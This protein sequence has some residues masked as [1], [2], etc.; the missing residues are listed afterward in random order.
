MAKLRSSPIVATD[1]AEYLG[2]QDDFSLELFVYS[3]SRSFGFTSTHGGTYEDPVTKKPRQY[4]VRA[5]FV[6]EQQR[7]DL[8]IECK[9]LRT[10]F[11]LLVS[12]IPRV[13][14]ESFHHVI[15]SFEPKRKGYDP[16]AMT[17]TSST[18]VLGSNVPSLYEA[19]QFVGKSTTQVGRNDKGDFVAGDSDVYDKWTQALG[20]IGELIFKAGKH[21]EQ[22]KMTHFSTVVIR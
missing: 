18:Y 12:R 1:L 2:E 7:I 15:H 16:I 21:H 20:S 6:R 17:R 22:Y 4:D 10:S 11:P 9:S 5:H 19:G 8:A 14:Q 3:T 13:E